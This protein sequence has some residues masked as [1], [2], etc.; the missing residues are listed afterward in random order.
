MLS[1]L[2]NF[3]SS[4]VSLKFVTV[5]PVVWPE[6]ATTG[7]SEDKVAEPTPGPEQ[8]ESA[9]NDVRINE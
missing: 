2:M 5:P 8:A 3:A 4:Q 9:R 1:R 6:P 7:L